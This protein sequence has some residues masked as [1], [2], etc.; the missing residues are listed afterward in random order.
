MTKNR[1]K[2]FLGTNIYSFK[3]LCSYRFYLGWA[4]ANA[5]TNKKEKGRKKEIAPVI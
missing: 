5:N 2:Y 3:E 1:K 4:R